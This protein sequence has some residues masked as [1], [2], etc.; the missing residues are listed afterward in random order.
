MYLLNNNLM[1]RIIKKSVMLQKI[2]L[3][4]KRL[5][6]LS[7]KYFWVKYDPDISY[8]CSIPYIKKQLDPQNFDLT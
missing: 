4:I 5:Y 2:I 8:R 3:A 6:F 7:A 1:F